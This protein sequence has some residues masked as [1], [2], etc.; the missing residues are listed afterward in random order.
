MKN[1]VVVTGEGVKIGN[2]KKTNGTWV[3][4]GKAY[5]ACCNH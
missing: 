2:I 3:T 5:E 4:A 1:P